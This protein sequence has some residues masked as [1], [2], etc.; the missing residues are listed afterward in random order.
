MTPAPGT[1]W[2][3]R[4]GLAVG[5]VAL[6]T[7]AYVGQD[8]LGARGQA[9]IGVVCFLAVA[10]TFSTNIRAINRRTVF[11]GIGLQ[12]F[13]AVMILKV[14]PVRDVF[15]WM[16]GVARQFL[17]FSSEGGRFVF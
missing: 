15:E 16:G 11:T 8:R 1:P 17:D 6:T 3:W 7:V 10:L 9:L 13:L 12:L 5:I 14:Q 4:L 2:S